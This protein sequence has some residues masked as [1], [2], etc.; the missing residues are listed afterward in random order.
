ME[1]TAQRAFSRADRKLQMV[2]AM[3]I[4]LEN[5]AQPH[6]TYSLAAALDMRVS[7]HFR[8]ILEEL[9]AERLVM[10]VETYHRP[11]WL[12]YSLV[13]Q[14]KM[15]R[16]LFSVAWTLHV[17]RMKAAGRIKLNSDEEQQEMFADWR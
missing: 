3:L 1:R 6:T 13:P 8:S 10:K 2:T 14:T 16:H 12:K 9:V 15:I 11:K 4:R 5:R 7:P 17:S